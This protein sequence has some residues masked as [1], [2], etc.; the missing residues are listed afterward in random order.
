MKVL[1][2]IC[3]CGTSILCLA[4]SKYHSAQYGISFRYPSTYDLKPGDLG[5]VEGDEWRLGYLGPIPM[6]FAASGGVRVVTVKMPSSAYPGTDLDI[7]FFTV[8][9][10][11]WIP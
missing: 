10:R 9:V 6:E 4:Q 3:F 5:D 1:A 11:A 7:A 8:S 2:I